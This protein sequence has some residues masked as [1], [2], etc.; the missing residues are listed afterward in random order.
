MMAKK[1][2]PKARSRKR[3]YRKVLRRQGQ[4]ENQPELSFR[5]SE[6]EVEFLREAAHQK[7]P[8][9]ARPMP[10]FLSEAALESSETILGRPRPALPQPAAVPA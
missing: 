4:I 2:G 7:Y 6:A 10:R 1:A 8:D 5:A 9:V 3:A